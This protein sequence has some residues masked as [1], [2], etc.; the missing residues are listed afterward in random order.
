[1]ILPPSFF[2]LLWPTSTA[3]AASAQPERGLTYPCFLEKEPR[4]LEAFRVGGKA[5]ETAEE[6]VR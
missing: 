4:E 3:L 5:D 1:M 6:V 2:T